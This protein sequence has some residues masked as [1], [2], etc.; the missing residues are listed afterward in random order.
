MELGKSESDKKNLDSNKIAAQLRR[1]QG[2]YSNI[3]SNL[4]VKL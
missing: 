2:E 4:T 1:K 3:T